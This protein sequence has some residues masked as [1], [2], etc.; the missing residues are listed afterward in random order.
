[1]KYQ[2]IKESA[3]VRDDQ[4]QMRHLDDVRKPKL[5]LRHLNKLR[6]LRELRELELINQ[7]KQLEMIY[8]SSS[9]SGDQ[10]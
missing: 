5:T 4:I 9:D 6:K 2:D 1:M 7:S 3:E 10:F 8:G